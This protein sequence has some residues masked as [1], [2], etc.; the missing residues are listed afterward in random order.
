[1]QLHLSAMISV[2]ISFGSFTWFI[3]LVWYTCK[4]H[5]LKNISKISFRS[6]HEGRFVFG[7]NSEKYPQN[8]HVYWSGKSSLE[9]KW[10]TEISQP[11][12][13]QYSCQLASLSRTSETK[14]EERHQTRLYIELIGLWWPGSCQLMHRKRERVRDSIKYNLY[15]VCCN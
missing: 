2:H 3:Y 4:V 6:T 10:V 12:R 8:I 14:N 13:T 9:T 15:N 7:I 1:M 11:I 5:R